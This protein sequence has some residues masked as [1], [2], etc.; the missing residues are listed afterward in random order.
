MGVYANPDWNSSL[1]KFDNLFN[2]N[3]P[4]FFMRSELGSE[5]V[6]YTNSFKNL[7]MRYYS[8]GICN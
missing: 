7:N 4:P 3:W 6:F 5:F 2:F 1:T 8:I